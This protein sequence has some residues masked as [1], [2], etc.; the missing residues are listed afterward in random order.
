[1]RAHHEAVEACKKRQAAIARAQHEI[2]EKVAREQARIDRANA[3]FN[4]E[5]S[6]LQ[7]ANAKYDS[8]YGTPSEVEAQTVA[9]QPVPQEP[10]VIRSKPE[11]EQPIAQPAPEPQQPISQAEPQQPEQPQTIVAVVQQPT[12]PATTPEPTEKPKS[13]P[14]TASPFDLIGLVGVVSM[15]SAYTTRFFRR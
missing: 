2:N 4:H 9:P 10:E 13:L 7:S 8:F 15:S 3:H 6:E 1:V 14:K 11:P 5:V 12:A